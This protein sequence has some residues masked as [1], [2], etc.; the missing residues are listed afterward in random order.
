MAHPL[1]SRHIGFE[2]IFNF[3]DLGGYQSQDGRTIVWRR[4]FRSAEIRRMTRQDLLR[5]KEELG[6]SSVVDLRSKLE[7]EKHGVG[8]VNE[9]G[10]QYHNI[11]FVTNDENTEKGP[12]RFLQFSNMG[13]VYLDFVRHPEYGRHIVEAL[14]IIARPEKHPL[15]FHC[16]AGKDRTGIL[17]A[18]LFGVLDIPDWTIVED[19]ALTEPYMKELKAR[20]DRDP[21]FTTESQNLPDYMWEAAEESMSLFLSTLKREYGS[22]RGYLLASGA[23]LELFEDLER[24]LLAQ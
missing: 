21:N 4:V 14:E 1:Y 23:S 7:L 9:W 22:A 24:V 11:P 13:E 18:I 8:M 2:R 16:A 6:I 15:V 3:R 17:T 20:L 12:E 10:F 19:Y 5:L